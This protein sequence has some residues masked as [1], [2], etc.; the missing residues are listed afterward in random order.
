MSKAFTKESDE[1]LDEVIPEPRD[2]LP[3][4]VKNYVTPVGAKELQD[5]LRK[6]EQFISSDKAQ[7]EKLSSIVEGSSLSPRNRVESLN[8]RI[9]FLQNRI[10]NMVI[11]DPNSQEKD[12]V[13]F[14]ATVAVVD[15]DGN[16][17]VYKIVG[18]DES[19]PTDGKVSFI[20]PI[21]KALISA[22]EG[23]IVRLELPEGGKEMEILSISY[24]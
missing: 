14:G 21:A 8:R 18:V 1:D 22:R 11:V 12:K 15:S 23:D 4:G 20:S 13:L 6:L 2:V 7:K 3:E 24:T 19:S 9:R 10:A 5:N 16:N 17:V